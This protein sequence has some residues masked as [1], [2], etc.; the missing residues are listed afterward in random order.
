MW[1]LT[2]NAFYINNK[3]SKQ[4][5]KELMFCIFQPNYKL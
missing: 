5:L 4:Y 1:I 3:E 2:L